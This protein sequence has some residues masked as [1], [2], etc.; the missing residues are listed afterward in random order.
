ML[1]T[2][3]RGEKP[4]EPVMVVT[5]TAVMAVMAESGG[6]DRN[7]P[8]AAID[9]SDAWTARCDGLEAA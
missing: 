2:H 9:M 6:V 4:K 7:G 5:A 1:D 8:P 3:G